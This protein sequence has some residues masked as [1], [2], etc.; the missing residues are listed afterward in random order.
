MNNKKL[1][2]TFK[3]ATKQ[4]FEELEQ[5]GII[6]DL[7]IEEIEETE[8]P[9]DNKPSL[10]EYIEFNLKIEQISEDHPLIDEIITGYALEYID[11]NR[12]TAKDIE[13]LHN[14]GVDLDGF[15]NDYKLMYTTDSNG[16]DWQLTYNDIAEELRAFVNYELIATAPEEMARED[17][18]AEAI[19]N[20]FQYYYERFHEITGLED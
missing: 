17:L 8:E 2:E 11:I 1:I 12:L 10:K 5:I 14:L 6:S 7:Q 16:N 4:A 3:E 9:K 13:L 15:E 19:E 20:C 18:E